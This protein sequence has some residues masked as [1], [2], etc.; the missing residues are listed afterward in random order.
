MFAIGEE[1]LG[2]ARISMNIG[3]PFTAGSVR[4]AIGDDRRRFVDLLGAAVA[5]ELPPQYRGSY[6]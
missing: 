4:S 6:A 2:S 5:R 1:R 3:A